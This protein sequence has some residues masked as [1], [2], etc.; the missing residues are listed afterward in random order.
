MYGLTEKQWKR[1]LHL[2]YAHT[3]KPRELYKRSCNAP[4]SVFSPC[5]WKILNSSD[6]FSQMS[7]GTEVVSLKE[8]FQ[9][10]SYLPQLKNVSKC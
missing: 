4:N 1:T 7:I 8:T 2:F 6:Y 5:S 10:P 9:V 3:Y